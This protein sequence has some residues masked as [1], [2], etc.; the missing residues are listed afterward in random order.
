ENPDFP[1]HT[2]TSSE[3]LQITRGNGKAGAHS[4]TP[5]HL[6]GNYIRELKNYASHAGV[7]VEILQGYQS[8]QEVAEVVNLASG[9]GVK[10]ILRLC[11]GDTCYYED[12][13]TLIQFM[14]DLAPLLAPNAEVWI[15]AGPNEPAT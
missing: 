11:T 2:L 4:A 1:Y 6:N 3:F 10:L 7:A 9:L 5:I 12:P 14:R 15:S 8:P 13:Q